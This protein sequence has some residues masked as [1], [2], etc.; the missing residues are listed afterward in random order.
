[1]SDNCSICD[2]TFSTKNRKPIVCIFCNKSCCKVCFSTF[3][4]DLSAPKCM[5]CNTEI[6]MDFVEENT[7][8]QFFTEYNEHLCSLKFSAER[9]KLPSTQRL[10][11]IIRLCDKYNEE[12]G[13][14]YIIR[15]DILKDYKNCRKEHKTKEE[16]INMIKEKKKIV[17]ELNDARTSLIDM[18][19]MYNGQRVREIGILT[20]VVQP[21]ATVEEDKPEYTRPCLA[22][23]CRGFLSKSYKCGTC[24]KFFCAECHEQKK[25]RVD[26]EHICNEEAKATIAMIRRDSKPCPKCSIPIEKVS[27]CSQMWCVSC[28]T[29]FDWNTMRIETGYIHN[30]EYLR[31]MRTNNQEIQ[32]NPLDNPV[33]GNCNE[34][35]SWTRINFALS[36]LGIRSSCWDEQHRRVNH[37]RFAMRNIPREK[38][39]EFVNLRTDYLLSKIS[40]EQ[41]NKKFRMIVKRNKLNQERY[42]VYD[43]YSNGMKDLFINLEH[44]KD[45]EQF[46]RSSYEL[47][48]Y[49]N[50][51]LTKINKKYGSRDS[52]Y[53]SIRFL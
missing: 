12:Q 22:T 39:E 31:W 7:T 17:D 24:D 46:R 35:P 19:N 25:S 48:T 34:M 3:T 45:Y 52:A 53:S 10:A 30:P 21:D 41:W 9:S 29:T 50:D 42:N 44:T 1:M 23:D 20:G 47:E 16:K 38:E 32:R 40:E 37:I 4:K 2:S 33:G 36:P 6:T 18:Y 43:L 8:K 13:N 27:G 51:Q 15:Q 26:G 5:F 11:E 49:S 14:M 28:H